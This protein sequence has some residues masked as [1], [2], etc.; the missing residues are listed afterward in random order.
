MQIQVRHDNTI[1]G[2]QQ[3]TETTVATVEG[4]LDRHA[5]HITT[6][7][8][9]YADENGPKGGGDDVRCSIEVRFEGMKPIGVTDHAGELYAALE[10]AAEK[11]ARMLDHHLGRLR[12]QMQHNAPK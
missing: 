8:V 7:E 9:H 1:Q 6:V 2:S 12:D 3:L 4:V 5:A 11:V 10:G